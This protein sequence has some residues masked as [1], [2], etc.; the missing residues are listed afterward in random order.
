MPKVYADLHY[1]F[2]ERFLVTS[3]EKIIGKERLVMA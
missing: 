2:M 1:N 3:E